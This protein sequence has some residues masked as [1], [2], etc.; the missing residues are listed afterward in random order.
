MSSR[1]PKVPFVNLSLQ[2]QPIQSQIAAVI[3]KIIQ[4]G[5]FI[6][7][8][9][10]AEFETA[11]AAASGVQYGVGVACGTDAIALGLQACG[12]NPGDEI[13]VPANTFIA[14][15]IAVIQAK[16]IPILVD[17][18]PE[19]ALIDLTAA[20]TAITSKTKAIIPVHLYG[21]M[22]SPSQLLDFANRHN[23]II[24]EDAAQAHLAEREGYRAGSVGKAAAFSFYPSKNLGCFGDGGMLITNDAE[25]AKTMRTFRNYGALS[26]YLH[27]EIGTNSRLDNLQAAILNIKLPYLEKWNRDRNLAAQHYNTLLEPLKHKGIVPIANHSSLG[28]IYHI[29]A[30]HI[31]EKSPI[32]RHTLQQKLAQEGIETGIHYPVPCHLQPA[33]QHLGNPGDF[34]HAETLCQQILSLPM[35]PGLSNTQIEQVVQAIGRSLN[36]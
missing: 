4:E 17:C 19:T 11:F 5:D 27:T 9:A 29:Y 36:C 21:Q 22:V 33:Y 25:L 31:T 8:Q 34:P 28:H 13:I 3:G 12:I 18:D 6:L 16:A 24:F 1:P 10:L 23:L 14:T 26:K 32:D 20:E 15:V 7:G 2:H 35:Y 30:I